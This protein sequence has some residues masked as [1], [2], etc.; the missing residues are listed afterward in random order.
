[1]LKSRHNKGNQMS[2]ETEPTTARL[3]MKE[4]QWQLREDAIL[5]A[6]I[7][8]IQKKRLSAMTLEDVT[9]AIGISR[10]TLYLHFRSKEDIFINI[11]IRRLRTAQQ[12]LTSQDPAKSV[13]ERIKEFTSACVFKRF[14][15]QEMQMY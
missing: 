10:P 5:D 6:A 11:A 13:G 1:M 2:T 14:S 3:S 9:E 12:A 7:E 4:R 8:L 15:E